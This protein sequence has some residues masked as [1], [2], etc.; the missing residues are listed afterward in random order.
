[1]L[2]NMHV[3]RAIVISEIFHIESHSSW[4][5]T[6]MCQSLFGLKNTCCV[7]IYCYNNYRI[8]MVK[9]QY[10]PTAIDMVFSTG[11]HQ[12]LCVHTG[13]DSEIQGTY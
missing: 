13:D 6:G 8:C 4:T 5:A 2:I 7:P 11:L 9:R 10:T 3:L 12:G 1:M